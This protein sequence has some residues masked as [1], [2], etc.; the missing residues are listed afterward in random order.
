MGCC[1]GVQFHIRDLAQEL[2]AR[3]HE[4]SVIAPSERQPGCDGLEEFVYPVGQR[5]L[6]I[7]TVPWHV[8]RS[9]RR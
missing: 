6:F 7:T 1:W 4:V 5:F 9:G 8:W 3:G 2:I